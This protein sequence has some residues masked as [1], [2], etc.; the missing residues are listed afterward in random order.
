MALPP[1]IPTSFVPYSASATARRFRTDYGGAFGFFAYGV[2]GLAVILALGVFLYGQVLAG[3]Q[4]AK[5]TALSKAEAAID[6]PA[7]E[8]FVRLRDRLVSG[9]SLLNAH[10]AFSNFFT[11]LETLL[12]ANSRL[13]TL[14]LILGADGTAK[15]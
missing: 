1:T 10:P 9:Q 3:T 5:D 11:V 12:L 14:H 4:A 2:L 7:A 6:S 15:L 8:G 13:T